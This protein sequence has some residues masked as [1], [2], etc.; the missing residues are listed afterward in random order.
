MFHPPLG[1]Q[2]PEMPWGLGATGAPPGAAG[3]RSPHQPQPRGRA[4]WAEMGSWG[5]WA[6][7]LKPMSAPG[8]GSS[9]PSATLEENNLLSRG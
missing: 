8:P 1:V 3:Q 7:P 6:G 4:G 5:G 2:Q 9:P